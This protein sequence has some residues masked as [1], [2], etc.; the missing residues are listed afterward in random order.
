MTFRTQGQVF[1]A[2]VEDFQETLALVG[3]MD[4]QRQGVFAVRRQ[5]E[6]VRVGDEAVVDDLAVATYLIG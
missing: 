6:T 2:M 3:N 4:C 5:G 1:I